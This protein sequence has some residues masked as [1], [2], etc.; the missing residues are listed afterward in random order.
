MV[1]LVVLLVI[2]LL[3]TL[4]VEFAF[5]TL[6]DLRL[7]ETYRDT[8]RAHYL[9][10]GGIRV[11]RII[12]QDDNNSYDALDET[13]AL[14]VQNYPVADGTINISIDDHGGRLD[15]NRLV[16]AQGNID[17]LFK[18]R[19]VRLLDLLEADDPE[20]MT[21]ALID[22][23]DA[24]DDNE[25]NGAENFYYQSLAQP[26]NCKNAPLDSLEELNLVRGFNR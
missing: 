12:L 19:T 16:T 15:L 13:W 3:V 5:S 14:G 17:P 1:L 9:A 21:D 25:P 10:K 23:L 26:Y 18:D 6:V 22:W 8:T 4:L 7:A 20:A 24:D 2:A 11:G